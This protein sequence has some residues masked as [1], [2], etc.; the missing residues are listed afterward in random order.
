MKI[1]RAN[2]RSELAR[3]DEEWSDIL[4][5]SLILDIQVECLVPIA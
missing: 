4:V 5:D 2:E 3:V 1:T